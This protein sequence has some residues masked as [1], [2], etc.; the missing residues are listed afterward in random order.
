MEGLKKYM[1]ITGISLLVV[2][3]LYSLIIGY[4]IKMSQDV[5]DV[6]MAV[7]LTEYIDEKDLMLPI[8]EFYYE[9]YFSINALN[10]KGNEI[11]LNEF[12]KPLDEYKTF[13]QNNF[14]Y[15]IDSYDCKYWS[16]VHTL[17]WKMN[18]EKYNWKL[19]YIT[20]DNHVFVMIYNES[21]YAI[22]DQNNINW[23]GWEY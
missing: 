4:T 23:Y 10:S 11:Y 14:L 21:G 13:I 22:L 15:D 8:P 20:T 18:K 16:Y 17:Y 12:S 19:D 2:F 6:I 5:E 3:V 9:K 1:T 7:Q